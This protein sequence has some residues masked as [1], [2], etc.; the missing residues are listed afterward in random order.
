[1]WRFF[2]LCRAQSQEALELAARDALAIFPASDWDNHRIMLKNITMEILSDH[3]P[4][5]PLY[6]HIYAG[7][8]YR[9]PGKSDQEIKSGLSHEVTTNP[10]PEHVDYLLPLLM[11][12]CPES[13]G[14]QGHFVTPWTKMIEIIV[15]DQPTV[16]ND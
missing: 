12:T 2:G 6:L 11:N 4:E 10:E 3:Q 15:D 5:T 9:N 14:W 8:T 16:P 13:A 7:L 1:M